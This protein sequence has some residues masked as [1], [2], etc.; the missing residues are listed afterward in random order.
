MDVTEEDFLWQIHGKVNIHYPAYEI[1]KE[2][3]DNRDAF[4]PSSELVLI[5]TT[6][7]W[8]EHLFEIER[9]NNLEGLIKFAIYED[10]RHM[11]RL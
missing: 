6:C 3:F 10:D 9:E 8:K 7:P 1:A 5:K 2:A 11:W 4:H